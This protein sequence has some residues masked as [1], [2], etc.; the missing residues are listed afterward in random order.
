M[1]KDIIVKYNYFQGKKV[2]FTPGWDCHGLPIEQQ[3]EKK[4][5]RA[6]KEAME[7][8]KLRELCRNHATKF[9]DIQKK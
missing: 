7:K 4:L 1:L 5:G 3:V 9:V 2:R 8:S 6:K